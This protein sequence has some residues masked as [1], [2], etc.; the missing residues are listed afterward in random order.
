MA[1]T[2]ARTSQTKAEL[3]EMLAEAVRNTEADNKRMQQQAKRNRAA[4]AA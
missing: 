2:Q 4:K 1:T 3:H